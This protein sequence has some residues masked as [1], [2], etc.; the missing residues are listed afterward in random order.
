M[1][2]VLIFIVS[3]VRVFLGCIFLLAFPLAAITAYGKN[4]KCINFKK[5]EK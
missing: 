4:D 1:I 2:D 3:N 5:R